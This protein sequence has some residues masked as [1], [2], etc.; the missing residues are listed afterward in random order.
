MLNTKITISIL[1]VLSLMVAPKC[2]GQAPPPGTPADDHTKNS[3]SIHFRFDDSSIQ[4]SYMNN[5]RTIERMD[6]IFNDDCTGRIDSISI[7]AYSS[8]EGKAS[9]NLK[10]SKLRA[11]AVRDFIV[12]RYR[13]VDSMRI[14]YTGSG[15]DWE[16]L[17]E[18]ASADTG[19]PEKHTVME[20]FDM[21][22]KDAL[23]T[24]LQGR[25]DVWNYIRAKYFP[26]LRSAAFISLSVKPYAPSQEIRPA[27][28]ASAE[29][30]AEE[31]LQAAQEP[32]P[33]PDSIEV[34]PAAVDQFEIIR[35]LAVK[36]NLLFDLATL[37]N[38]EAEYP[39]SDRFSIMGEWTF[40][41]WLWSSKQNCIQLLNGGLEGRYWFKPDYRFQDKP[42]GSHN[43]LTGWFAGLYTSA[44]YYDLEREKEGYQ[45]E[46]FVAAGLSGGYVMPLSRNFSIEYSLGVGYL[47]SNYRHYEATVGA[48]NDWH[49][50][51][52][53]NGTVSWFGPTK[54][55]ISLVWYPHFKKAQKGG[56]R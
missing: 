1:A 8:P 13:A 14:N 19:L 54:A 16:G 56:G 3:L 4:P 37:I 52:Q 15:E 18:M 25:T 31:T 33:M 48:D 42:L 10:L 5:A 2:F 35:P 45:G 39:L 50:I 30:R 41:W 43:P 27:P 40:P 12:S 21:R 22:D 23:K 29:E 28:E 49:L 24:A 26:S 47:R 6:V 38:I 9:Y 20:L 36:T 44:G 11:K 55:K 53:N 51:R 32:Q 7:D 34:S 17:R 46:F